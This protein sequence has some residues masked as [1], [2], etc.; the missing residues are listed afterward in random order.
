[1]K[2]LG[3]ALVILV[4]CCSLLHVI[5]RHETRAL[6]AELRALNTTRDE[7]IEERGRIQLELGTWASPDRIEYIARRELGLHTN[8]EQGIILLRP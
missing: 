1:M 7:L 3:V 6:Y 8:A 2:I 5:V 4:F